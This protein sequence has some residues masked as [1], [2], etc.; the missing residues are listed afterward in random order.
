MAESTPVSFV[1]E[2]FNST[3]TLDVCGSLIPGSEIPSLDVSAEAVFEVLVS[4]MQNSF[5]YHTDSQ[6]ITDVPATDL[7]FFV[8]QTA[9]VWVNTNPANSVVADLAAIYIGEAGSHLANN[10]LMVCHDFI[11]YLASQLFNTH[12][13]VDLF[14][15]ESDLRENVRTM[16]DKEDV[17]HAWG[18]VLAALTA[19]QDLEDGDNGAP[20]S[21]GTGT[22]DYKNVACVLFRQMMKL[23][24]VRFHDL[25]P[26]ITDTANKY[27]IPFAAGDSIDFKITI[28]AAPDQE[29]LTGVDPIVGRSYR[30][31]L[32]LKEEADLTGL[33]EVAE[34]EL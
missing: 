4:D 26:Y 31:K 27:K 13:A 6:D 9:D 14:N 5:M 3:I 25:S 12:Y 24:A 34:D 20:Y 11:R 7:E 22:D 15:N 21:D 23:N 30:I 10:K 29:K 16:C 32:L 2:A 17:A 8:D 1:L 33:N 28:N 19:A 18:S